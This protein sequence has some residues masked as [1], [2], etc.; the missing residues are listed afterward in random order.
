MANYRASS[1]CALS[2]FAAIFAPIDGPSF[3]EE[4]A[5][6]LEDALHHLYIQSEEDGTYWVEA[7]QAVKDTRVRTTTPY[8]G[9]MSLKRGEVFYVR[10][11]T[12]EPLVQIEKIGIDSEVYGVE[13]K[14]WEDQL[15]DAAVILPS[16][17]IYGSPDEAKAGLAF[18]RGGKADES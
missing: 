9:I 1:S 10:Y 15:V 7:C 16:S 5:L 14:Y 8:S 13:R 11:D 2:L 12:D 6:K 3:N 18:R 4:Q 17:V